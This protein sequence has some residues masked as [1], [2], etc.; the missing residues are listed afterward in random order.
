MSDRAAPTASDLPGILLVDANGAH[1]VTITMYTCRYDY[2]YQ[3]SQNCSKLV[4]EHE[5]TNQNF[6]TSFT[7]PTLKLVSVAGHGNDNSVYG[8]VPPPVIRYPHAEILLNTIDVQR[9]LANEKIF[10]FL[11]CCTANGLGQALVNIGA[12]A[13][14]SYSKEFS[15]ACGHMWMVKPDCTILQELIINGKTIAQAKVRTEQKCADLQKSLKRNLLHY[16]V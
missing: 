11:A 3:I 14:I 13:C 15:L 2:L 5:A 10:H 1:T 8:Y 6:L 12:I 9:N 4:G 16:V 7:E